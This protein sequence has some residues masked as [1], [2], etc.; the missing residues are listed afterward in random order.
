MRSDCRTVLYLSSGS[1]C[2]NE[3]L[4]IITTGR[5]RSDAIEC[6]T[7]IGVVRSC[8]TGVDIRDGIVS[9]QVC[10]NDG[11][12]SACTV[13]HSKF[14]SIR[15]PGGVVGHDDGISVTWYVADSSATI[16]DGSIWQS[17]S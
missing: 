1:I 15:T 16:G 13:S 7:S 17:C 11:W 12:R 5:S 4:E 14:E 2:T 3:P 10:S 6:S 8:V 9:S